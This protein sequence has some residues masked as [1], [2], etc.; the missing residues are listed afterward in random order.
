[1]A[2]TTSS[3]TTPMSSEQPDITALMAKIAQLEARIEQLDESNRELDERNR[4][5]DKR[6]RSL[7]ERN[8]VIAEENKR[9]AANC[10]TIQE[11]NSKLQNELDVCFAAAKDLIPTTRAIFRVGESFKTGDPKED[12]YLL[13]VIEAVAREIHR[14]ALEAQYLDHFRR[15]GKDAAVTGVANKEAI[16][17]DSPSCESQQ[18]PASHADVIKNEIDKPLQEEAERLREEVLNANKMMTAVNKAVL[19]LAKEEDANSAIQAA[20]NIANMPEPPSNTPSRQQLPGRQKIKVKG[21]KSSNKGQDS[22]LICPECGKPVT[23]TGEFVRHIKT[24]S[25]SILSRCELLENH[26]SI[27]Y[28]HDCKRAVSSITEETPVP[29]KPQNSNTV[30]QEPLIEGMGVQTR[31]FSRSAAAKFIYELLQLGHDTMCRHE[32]EWM[33]LYGS[34][35]LKGIQAQAMTESVLI[36][37][38]TPFRCLELEGRGVSTLRKNKSEP[39][40]AKQGYVL[41][42]CNTEKSERKFVIFNAII[43]RS[44][45]AIKEHLE[46]YLLSENLEL[47]VT[48]GYEAYD[49]ILGQ[50]DWGV[51]RAACWTHWRRTV[52]KAVEYDL[53]S[54]QVGQLSIEDAEKLF[55]KRL[56]EKESGKYS[57]SDFFLFIIEAI[58]LLYV[59]ER[60][61]QQLPDEPQEVFLERVRNNRNCLA[62][63]VVGYI[64]EIVNYMQKGM[65]VKVGK[66]YKAAPNTTPQQAAALT[67]YLNNRSEL[68]TFLKDPRVPL[69]TNAVERCIRPVACLEGTTKYRQTASHMQTMCDIFT[70]FETAKRNGISRPEEYLKRFGRA[71]YKY[72]FEKRWT[73]EFHEKGVYTVTKGLRVWDMPKLMEGFDV[74]PWLPWNYKEEP[75]PEA[76]K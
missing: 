54:K 38:E 49:T 69:D 70:L 25:K 29:M 57:R 71:A 5:L 53:L 34:V 21:S 43:G 62:R 7:D 2:Q 18:E 9:I 20:A 36:S 22:E 28:C 72:C 39:K 66:R 75:L 50:N 76:V 63:K 65:V 33:S 13:G 32:R 3:V 52:I 44:A 11:L 15:V 17:E 42:I 26:T 8:K 37:D 59:Y 68:T 6:N 48:D 60:E 67:Y 16:K 45:K 27:G 64:D 24:L 56:A 73:Q 58:R 30:A 19:A 51:T 55:K 35:L 12:V 61:L 31:G 10:R 46:P 74:T 4:T 23:S 41:S 47:L 40:S 1:M 14:I